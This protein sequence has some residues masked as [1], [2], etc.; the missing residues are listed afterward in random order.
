MHAVPHLDRVS[1]DGTWRFQLLRRPTIPSADDWGKAE[2]P[3][4]W[5]MQGTWDLPIYTNVQ[6]PFPGLPPYAAGREPDGR[7]R[8]RRSRSPPV[9]GSPDRALVGAAE[10]ALI[11][12]GQRRSTSG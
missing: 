2:V 4:C 12:S 9:G 8:A 6:M 1:L 3:G 7:V 5:T 10:S 11:V